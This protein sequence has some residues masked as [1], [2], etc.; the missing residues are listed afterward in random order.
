MDATATLLVTPRLRLRRFTVADADRLVALD[1][2]PVVMRYIA[3]GVPTPRDRILGEILPRWIAGY[4]PGSCIGYWAAES[5]ADG[6]FLGWFHLRP[7]RFAREDMELGYRLRRQ[8]WGVGLATEG[9]LALLDRALRVQRIATVSA[10]TLA[11]NAASRRVI[12]KCGLRYTGEFEYPL[13]MLP[14]WSAQERRAVWYFAERDAWL[15][16]RDQGG[17]TPV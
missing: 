9:S 8:H 3:R 4:A 13:T 7:D 15:R 11:G 14:G 16:R 5:L 12:E 10:R 1:A 6:D 17:A 2:D